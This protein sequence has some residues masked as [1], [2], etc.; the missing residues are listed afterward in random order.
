MKVGKLYRESE[1]LI[2]QVWL[3]DTVLT[4]AR[5]LLGRPQ[6]QT[7]EGLVIAPCSS[8][9]TFGMQYDLD[10]VFLD[11]ADKVVKVVCHLG[12]CRIAM[13]I[14]AKRTLELRAGEIERLNLKVGDEL[15]WRQV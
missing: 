12:K 1:L 6:L 4:R 8:I 5:G 15:K 13:S 10:I 14:R 3:A 7:C 2:E 9:H 11:S